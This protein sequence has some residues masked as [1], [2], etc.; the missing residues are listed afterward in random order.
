[1]N[2]ATHG[3]KLSPSPVA[4]QNGCFYTFMPIAYHHKS[5]PRLWVPLSPPSCGHHLLMFFLAKLLNLLLPA[6]TSSV[7][8]H[9]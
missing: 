1:M 7:V 9:K 8:P 5:G 3:Q 6:H 2:D 4:T